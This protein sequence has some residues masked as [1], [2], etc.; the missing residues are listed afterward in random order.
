MKITNEQAKY[1][2]KL[3]KKV[4]EGD[5]LLDKLTIDQKFPFNTRFELL[6]EKDDEFTFLWEIRQSKKNSVRVSLHQQ[7]NDSK[8]GL[9]R[10]DYNSGHKNPENISEFVPEEFHRYA[11]K[12]F[13]NN[14]HHIHYHI[15]GYKSLAWAIPLTIDEFE[16]KELNDGAGFNTTFADIIKLFAKTVNIETAITVNTLLL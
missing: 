9:L 3:P 15:Q 11:G 5:T 4:L 16:I 1:L 13:S 14:E 10:I 12:Y 2:L 8:T 6:S 7:E